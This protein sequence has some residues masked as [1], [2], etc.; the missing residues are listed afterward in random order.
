MPRNLKAAACN[1]V[2]HAIEGPDSHPDLRIE[3]SAARCRRERD[4]TRGR[5][6]AHLSG[7]LWTAPWTRRGYFKWSLH[8]AGDDAFFVVGHSGVSHGS[9]RRSSASA[10]TD[11]MIGS[12]AACSRGRDAR[13]PSVDSHD[14]GRH[15]RSPR[16]ARSLGMRCDLCHIGAVRDWHARRVADALSGS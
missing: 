7:V 3:R 9:G 16:G 12:P 11:R 2:S 13:R 5:K 6:P 4:S 14:G 15:R 8:H 10:G 1:G